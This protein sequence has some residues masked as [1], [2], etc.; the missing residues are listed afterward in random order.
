[1]AVI[2]EGNRAVLLVVDVQVGVMQNV[3]QAPRTIQNIGFAV[4][5]ARDQSA[6]VIWVQ[7]ADHDLVEGSVAWEVVPELSPA[8]DE[9]R[10]HK[11]F[12]SSFEE[13]SLEKALAAL[14]ATHIVLAGAATNWCVRAT[15]YGALDRGYDLTLL[16][17]AHTTERMELEDGA[18][19][20]AADIICALNTTM[21]WLR[22]L[23]RTN[24]A[25]P[26]GEVEFSL[27]GGAR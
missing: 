17:D 22:Y 26:V 10:I 7:H 11:P 24:T 19:I 27:P 9:M 21:T 8:D 2:R 25:A 4:E 3:W 16:A 1:M 23:G 18:R 15:A 12:N 14:G 20:E 5:K 13:T 6:P